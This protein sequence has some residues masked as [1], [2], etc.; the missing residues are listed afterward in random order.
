M[1]SKLRSAPTSNP[2]KVADRLRNQRLHSLRT[3]A[4]GSLS[5]VLFVQ[6]GQNRSTSGFTA[7]CCTR[8]LAFQPRAVQHSI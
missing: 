1:S 8:L 5:F 4:G 6:E 3:T 2:C 7:E